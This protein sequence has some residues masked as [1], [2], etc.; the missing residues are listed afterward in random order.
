[1]KTFLLFLWRWAQVRLFGDRRAANGR[2]PG[3]GVK[4]NRFQS[5]IEYRLR[6]KEKRIWWCAEC[7]FE[8]SRIHEE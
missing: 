5:S 8:I 1:M 6:K 4:K 7:Y 2:C 3:C